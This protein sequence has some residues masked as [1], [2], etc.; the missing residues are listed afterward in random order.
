[1]YQV[2][3]KKTFREE[4][5]MQLLQHNDVLGSPLDKKAKKVASQYIDYSNLL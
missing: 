3:K 1:M 5:E 2:Q 4:E